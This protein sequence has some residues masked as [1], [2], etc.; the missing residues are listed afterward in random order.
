VAKTHCAVKHQFGARLR[1]PHIFTRRTQ[2]MLPFP[3]DL[4]L[5]P[6]T[7]FEQFCS[8]VAFYLV[9]LGLASLL[10]PRP[11]FIALMKIAFPFLPETLQ[12]DDH[13]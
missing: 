13:D 11:W 2:T 10:L 12:E 4:E 1:V 8:F 9:L 6:P 7:Q 3:S 5:P